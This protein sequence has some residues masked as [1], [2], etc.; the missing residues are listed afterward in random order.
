MKVV[1]F[2]ASGD[3]GQAQMRQLVAAGHQPLAAA[4][5][6]AS[7]DPSWPTIAADYRDPESLRRA[8]DGADAVFLTLPSTSFQKAQDVHDAAARVADAARDAG[9]PL[10]IFN[11]SMII[12]DAPNGFAAHDARHAIR[13]SL[14]DSAVPTISI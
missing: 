2:G 14:F 4:R 5:N 10:L 8:A 6:P 13:Q 12:C 7:L 3:Q 11:S 9:V 1:V